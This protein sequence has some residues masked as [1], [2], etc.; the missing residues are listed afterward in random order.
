MAKKRGKAWVRE[1]FPGTGKQTWIC[2]WTEPS[3]NRRIRT[4]GPGKAG[5]KLAETL[6]DKINT[7]LTLGIYKSEAGTVPDWDRFVEEYLQKGLPSNSRTGTISEARSALTSF[8]K[9]LKIGKKPVNVVSGKSIDDF[10]SARLAERG[11]QVGSTTSIET[12]NRQLRRLKAALRT[13]LRWKYIEEVPEIKFLKGD[14]KLHRFVTPEHFAAILNA[15]KSSTTPDGHHF[16]AETWWR[17]LLTFAYLTGWRIGEILA[18]DWRDVDLDAGT[19]LTRAE[20]NKGRRD[21]MVALH[22][23]IVDAIR[24]LKGFQPRVFPWKADLKDLYSEFHRLQA[25]A[26][27]SLECANP[28]PHECSSACTRYGFH[29]LRRAFATLNAT[30]MPAE[31]LQTLMRHASY[32]TTQRYIKLA[33][34]L[35]PAM[36][37]IY[38]PPVLAAR[39]ASETETGS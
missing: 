6:R 23:V 33:E 30:R 26:E 13:A 27:I 39:P 18:L 3:G 14:R 7:E 10:V 24:P 25:A 36:Q 38:V 12:V 29:D 2:E 20:S 11:K 37:N 34:E 5:K 28:R 9:I 31:V 15:C 19:A 22:S 16:A 32:Q 35:T 1:R 21:S 8:V 4:C 17:G